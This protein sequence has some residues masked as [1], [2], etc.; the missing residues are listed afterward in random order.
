M[1]IQ[2]NIF[3]D[4][5]WVPSSATDT[6][7]VV[8]PATEQPIATVPNGTVEDADRA[9]H[10]AVAAFPGW[11]Q[12]TLDTRIAVMRSAADVLEARLSQVSDDICE[13]I[14]KPVLLARGEVA[15]VVSGLRMIGDD[16][17]TVEWEETIGN[18][19]IVREP[20]GVVVAITAWNA[21]LLEI[22][23]KVC[24]AIAAGCTVVLKPSERAPHSA[25]VFAEVFEAAGLPAGVLNVVVG[26]GPVVGEALVTHPLT[27]MVSIT[28]SVGAG[29]RVMEL[30]ARGVK[31]V[32]LELGGKSPNVIFADADLERAV[33]DGVD[34]CLRSA[35]QVCAGLT[36]MIVPA[37]LV[38]RVS[39]IAK[40]RAESYVI[41]DPAD[42]RTTLGPVANADQ[43]ER[44]RD[45]IRLG[46]EEGA[47]TVTGGVD[48]P[49]TVTEGYYIRPTI[50]A[51]VDNKMR[52]AQEEIFGPVLSIIGFDTEEEAIEIAND[53]SY[54]LGAAVWSGDV[55]RA[56]A[57]AG[58]LRAGRVRVNGGP[59][60][61]AA[62]H[63]GFKQ[64]GMGREGGRFGIEEFLDLKAILT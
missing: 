37:D 36:R 52:I 18:A 28:G 56:R 14:G 16:L 63:G 55:A 29:K 43:F 51:G 19:I 59:I 7:T 50:F 57:V 49:D 41:G 26:T 60:N 45:Y 5:Q 61:R 46:I 35:G 9:V 8:N 2:T 54:G 48:F 22:F 33:N 31:R 62:P 38:E 53:T 3:I 27:D 1:R 34:D 6:I 13:E 10:A 32:A 47:T 39:E 30:A 42:E 64:S 44:V 58:R 20:I 24:A 12:S 11:S 17:P 23:V 4:G 40:V 15:A 25:Y 21:P